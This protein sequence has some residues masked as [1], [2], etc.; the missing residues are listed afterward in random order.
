MS[1][2]AVIFMDLMSSKSLARRVWIAAAVLV[3]SMSHAHS[4]GQAMFYIEVPKDGGIYVF[5]IGQ[6]YDSFQKSGGAEFGVPAIT[7]P[8][9]GPAGET[10]VFDS[11]DAVN[12][13][14]FKHDLPG[15]Y[16]PPTSEEKPKSPSSTGK[17]SGLMFG[18][19]YWYDRWH[20]DQIGPADP[21]TVEGQNGFWLRRIFFTYD[22]TFNE[23]LTTRFRIEANSNGQFAG[24]GLDPYVKDAYLKWTY[25]GKQEATLGIQ[26]SLTIDWPE[27]FWGMRHIEKS[28][29]DLYRIDSSR[30]F[31]I[32]FS[33]PFAI[34]GL[35]YAAQFGNDSGNGSETDTYKA[36]RFEGR[37]ERSPG[38]ALEVLYGESQ[39][40]DDQDRTT[41]QGFAGYRHEGVRL[42]AQY[43]WQKRDSGAPGVADQTIDIWSAFVVWDVLP[44]RAN[45]FARV[46]DVKGD[47]DGVETGLPGA[48]GIDYLLVSA[49]AP[50]TTW[51][52]GGE[53]FLTSSIRAGP[54]VE[55]V[56]Y[57]H[58]PDPVNLPGRDESRL[59]RVTF[60]WTF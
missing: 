54:N 49:D 12:L 41:A 8:A 56:K 3:G 59:Y 52:V 55:I 28:P 34:E 9:Y 27:A 30:D 47:L 22:L 51:I 58:D 32:T 15:E 7:R 43:V 37:Y 25:K 39:R 24:G 40:P 1:G 13:Y 14:N 36:V 48:A 6:R 16:F 57:D 11:E 46:D 18:D 4:S 17:F 38:I 23:T 19:Y 50:F 29:A 5:A 2:Q 44:K 42:G 45:L 26:P 20:A 35:H 53:W 60:F 33:G 21:T 31:G 10:V